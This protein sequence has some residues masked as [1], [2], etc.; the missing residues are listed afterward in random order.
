MGLLVAGLGMFLAGCGGTASTPSPGKVTPAPGKAR[1]ATATAVVPTSAA[2]ASPPPTATQAEAMVTPAA[3]A[4]S[5]TA[6]VQTIFTNRCIKCHSGQSPPRGL[7]LDSYEHV[8]AGGTYRPVVLPGKPEESEIV[9]RIKGS[10]ISRMPFD[11]P[12]F[13][14]DEQIATIEAWIAAG[15]PNN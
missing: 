12:P 1:V 6:D 14:T 11:G 9:R 7:R 13:L 10:A 3:S 15:A 8:I 4:P 2:T 5:F